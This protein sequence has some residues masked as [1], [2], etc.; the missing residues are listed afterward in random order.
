MKQV[1]LSDAEWKIM[2]LLWQQS[3]MT[4]MQITRALEED[5]GW[6]KHTVITMLNRMEAKGAV[7]HREGERAKLF[8]P[9]ADQKQAAA[10]ETRG[11]LERVYQGSLSM[12][13]NSM[14]SSRELSREEIQELCDILKKAEEDAHD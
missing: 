9:L 13:V 12:M 5:T 3:P 1:N 11:F 4:I 7:A 14:A 2:N 10:R 6:G 8:Y